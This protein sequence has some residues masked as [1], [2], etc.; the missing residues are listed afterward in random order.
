MANRH[1]NE[2]SCDQKF[3]VASILHGEKRDITRKIPEN[4]RPLG[5][6]RRNITRPTKFRTMTYIYR[7]V[8][9]SEFYNLYIDRVD[10]RWI[11]EA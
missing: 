9:D 4:K 7:N 8:A 2:K 11:S 3:F 10:V 6:S 5:A 1:L